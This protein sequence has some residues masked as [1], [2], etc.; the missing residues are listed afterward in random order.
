MSMKKSIIK[1]LVIVSLFVSAT[2]SAATDEEGF[3]LGGNMGSANLETGSF[4]KSKFGLGFYGGYRF[5]KTWGIE[6]TL[7]A[8]SN[9][10]DKGTITAAGLTLAPT[11]RYYFNNNTSVFVKAG[12]AGGGVTLKGY[13]FVDRRFYGNGFVWG[14]GADYSM[15]DNLDLRLSYE[16]INADLEYM[17][18]PV[19]VDQQFQSNWITNSSN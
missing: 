12:V 16:T 2:S 13:G 10:A 5:S 6:S 3:Y 8:S 19:V 15:T 14:I 18:I 11:L 9:L 7:F 1:N 17:H 4:D